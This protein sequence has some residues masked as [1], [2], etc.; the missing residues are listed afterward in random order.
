MNTNRQCRGFTLIETMVAVVAIGVII[1]GWLAFN[2]GRD[3]DERMAT[4]VAQEAMEL[5]QL[6]NA[7]ERYVT[8]NKAALFQANTT[9]EITMANLVSAGNLPTNFATR[10]T[11]RNTVSVTPFNQ[12]YR[13]LTATDGSGITRIVVTHSDEVPAAAVLARIGR[14]PSD[15]TYLGL[16]RAVAARVTADRAVTAGI[17]PKGSMTA[18]GNF[19]GY[20]QNLSAWLGSNTSVPRVVVLAGFPEFATG[21]QNGG[22]DGEE[23]EWGDCRIVQANDY[24]GGVDSVCPNNY[25]EV[26]SWRHCAIVDPDAD[27]VRASPVGALVFGRFE[28]ETDSRDFCGGYFGGCS[29][30]RHEGSPLSGM[31]GWSKDNTTNGTGSQWCGYRGDAVGASQYTVSANPGVGGGTARATM[32]I[33]QNYAAVTSI[34]MAV[35]LN[36]MPQY[37]S[38]CATLARWSFGTEA[39][40]RN[41]FDVSPSWKKGYKDRLCCK[42][43]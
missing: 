6:A 35:T 11:S 22:D 28:T 34:V 41:T 37:E 5:T 10:D 33:Y 32:N 24:S 25:T 21:G 40:P 14:K 9:R 27:P 12:A 19:N 31:C 7:A 17:V 2:Q 36:G 42:P 3:Q 26:A 29:T 15:E 4:L 23:G 8:A 13:V 39:S 20:S 18:T 1:I 30:T 43:R 38:Q 16:A